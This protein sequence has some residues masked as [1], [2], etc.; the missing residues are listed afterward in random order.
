MQYIFQRS[1]IFEGSNNNVDYG[2][3]EVQIKAT[4]E[5]RARKRLPEAGAGRD[6]ILIRSRNS[7]N[8]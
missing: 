1:K 3:P 2:T 7:F 8:V 6:W 5:A 4:S